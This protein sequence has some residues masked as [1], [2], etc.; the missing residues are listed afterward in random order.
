MKKNAIDKA[1]FTFRYDCDFLLLLSNVDD[2]LILSSSQSLYFKVRDKL[3]TMF[4][5]TVQEGNT[6]NFLNLRIVSSPYA[7]SMDQTKHI[8]NTV[9]H[10]FP[11][12]Q[13]WTK[14]NTPIRTDKEYEKE[15]SECISATKA[16]LTLLE[17]EFGAT[18]Y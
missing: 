11:R 9:A 10:F 15:Y 3:K 5:I 8:L 12:M 17:V 6:I 13:Q 7:I 18:I 14:K 4:D 1:V 16:E 2:F